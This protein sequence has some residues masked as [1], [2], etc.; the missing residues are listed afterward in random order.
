M[1]DDELRK[2]AEPISLPFAA[3]GVTVPEIVDVSGLVVASTAGIYDCYLSEEKE[4][5]AYL[6]AAANA[7]PALLDRLAVYERRL[8][9]MREALRRIVQAYDALTA[10]DQ[11]RDA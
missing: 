1:T 4:N 7:V 9:A 8:T 11:A 3:R 5:M 6:A 2:L 10:D